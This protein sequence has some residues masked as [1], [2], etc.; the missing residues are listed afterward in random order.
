MPP[1]P[2]PSPPS[3]SPHA[4]T[5]ASELRHQPLPFPI[6]V[7]IALIEHVVLVLQ[8]A[9]ELTAGLPKLSPGHRH[10]LFELLHLEHQVLFEL[11]ALFVEFRGVDLRADV[12]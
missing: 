11:G 12:N 9:I 5:L 10:L 8:V 1:A 3:P 2:P 7:S 6:L 4:M